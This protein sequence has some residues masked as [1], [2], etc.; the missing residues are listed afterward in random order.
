MF[1]GSGFYITDYRK[2]SS[3]D[4]NTVSNVASPPKANQTLAD[5]SQSSNGNNNG[6]S[7]SGNNIT[8]D[9]KKN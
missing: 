5:K 7:E 6:K 1:K 2:S 8:K 3:N 4:K 9:S